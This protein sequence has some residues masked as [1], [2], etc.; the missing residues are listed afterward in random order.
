VK[1][2]MNAIREVQSTLRVCRISK[3][4]KYEERKKINHISALH[5]SA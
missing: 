5:E 4:E 2:Q 1:K 3:L